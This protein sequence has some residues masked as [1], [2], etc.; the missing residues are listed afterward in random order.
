MYV[1][2]GLVVGWGEGAE[3]S[4][5]QAQRCIQHHWPPIALLGLSADWPL[6]PSSSVCWSA[7]RK[8]GKNQAGGRGL[9]ICHQALRGR[10]GNLS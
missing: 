9:V 7:L 6:A 4:F 2:G 1:G 5:G 3:G 8:Q 10:K